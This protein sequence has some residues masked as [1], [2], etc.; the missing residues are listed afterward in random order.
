MQTYF[1]DGT[2]PVQILPT[3]SVAR[4]V[5]IDVEGAPIRIKYDGTTSSGLNNVSG[6]MIWAGYNLG[7]PIPGF[8]SFDDFSATN[9]I[10]AI[11]IKETS[12][13]TVQTG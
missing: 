11:A 2:T 8:R 13:V 12:K 10:Y 9:T 4:W 6:S 1:I 7:M 5:T 3:G